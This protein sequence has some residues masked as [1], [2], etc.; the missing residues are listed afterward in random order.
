VNEEGKSGN[1]NL[2]IAA[3]GIVLTAPLSRLRRI[4]RDEQH[5]LPPLTKA[6]RILRRAK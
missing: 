2:A 4:A 5:K 3:G 6:H 1:A